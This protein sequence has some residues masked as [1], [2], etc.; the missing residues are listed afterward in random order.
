MKKWLV[1]VCSLIIVLL[2]MVY[3][4]IPA[5]Q[6]F[7][8]ARS[9]NSADEAVSRFMINKTKWQQ[10]W[11]GEKKDDKLYSYRGFEYH[12]NKIMLNA[13]DITISNNHD[14]VK[15]LLRVFQ[16]TSTGT[17]LQWS[18]SIEFSSNPISRLF[19][20]FETK[21][22]KT[23]ISSLLDDSKNF[24]DKQENVY[25]MKIQAET[26]K[27]SALVSY[28]RMFDHY[29]ATEEIYSMIGSVNN[30]IQKKG[31]RENGS[32]MMHVEIMGLKE[33]LT[34]VAIPT[35]GDLP[36][37]GEFKAKKMILGNI[38]TGEVK[39]GLYTVLKAEAE[40]KNFVTDFRR[41]SPAIPYQSLITNRLLEKDTS[42][43]VTKL[44][45]PIF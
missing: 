37:E 6:N 31:G 42:K 7:I 20:Y 15:G 23:N 17:T 13:A 43:W 22:F 29:P 18:S 21:K 10:W 26:V 14:S 24:F 1:I 39:G 33:F 38:L 4:F 11:P 8:F 28:S 40:L 2:G 25:G 36:S 44:Y 45:Y 12:I 32:P 41:M 30:Y 19:Q 34:M 9:L 5:S 16:D 3:L 27:D 35:Q